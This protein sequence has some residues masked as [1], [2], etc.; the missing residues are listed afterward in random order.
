[1]ETSLDSHVAIK[2]VKQVIAKT[3]FWNAVSFYTS[4][5]LGAL[6]FRM[7]SFCAW[8]THKQHAV[9]QTTVW[10]LSV[11]FCFPFFSECV[12]EQVRDQRAREISVCLRVKRGREQVW[13]QWNSSS[14]ACL[15]GKFD[16][17]FFFIKF[18]VS[19]VNREAT[20]RLKFPLFELLVWTSFVAFSWRKP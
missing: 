18:N 5:F 10:R 4:S 3:F 8:L 9:T 15:S 7:V 2:E 12:W 14:S 20:S 6:C 17:P 11:E 13:S 16:T 1:M 19:F